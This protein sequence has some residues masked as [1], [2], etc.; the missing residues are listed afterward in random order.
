MKA[1]FSSVKKE[2]FLIV[3]ANFVFL[4]SYIFTP[5]PEKHRKKAEINLEKFKKMLKRRAMLLNLPAVILLFVASVLFFAK[6]PVLLSIEIKAYTL[7]FC[8][9]TFV[10][11]LHF[12]GV[13]PPERLYSLFYYFAADGEVR[14]KKSFCF[15]ILV[16]S[17][18]V[19]FM[20]FVK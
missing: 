20:F 1:F 18:I 10:C 6:N 12:A 19:F 11:L 7:M 16:P 8:V 3:F 15:W 13:R 14:S 2:L 4:I 17:L 9:Y 5:K